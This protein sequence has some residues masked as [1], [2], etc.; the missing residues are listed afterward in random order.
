MPGRGPASTTGPLLFIIAGFFLECKDFW[1]A[2]MQSNFVFIVYYIFFQNARGHRPVGRCPSAA[3]GG[4]VCVRTVINHAISSAG[5]QAPARPTYPVRP[6]AVQGV[7]PAARRITGG[8]AGRTGAAGWPG[9]AW[10]GRTGPARSS[11][12]SSSF[13]W[14]YRCHGYGCWRR[15]GSPRRHP[16]C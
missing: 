4:R 2:I 13:P 10:P 8:V 7:T 16:G 1:G 11:W 12:C 3:R 14:P 6:Q 5:L 15:T 9:P